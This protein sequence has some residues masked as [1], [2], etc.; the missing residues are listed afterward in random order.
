[1]ANAS[2]KRISGGS[3][4][5]PPSATCSTRRCSQSPI[6][7]C[8]EREFVLT[9]ELNACL[10][11]LPE[12][13]EPLLDAG[14]INPSQSASASSNSRYGDSE[15]LQ[16]VERLRSL[17]NRINSC[18][19]QKIFWILMQMPQSKPMVPGTK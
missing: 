7:V 16:C 17:E 18:Y 2:A 10:D 5:V 4:P 9:L 12:T 15:L 13:E 8:H 6:E 1:M 3:V 11:T 19:L 14:I